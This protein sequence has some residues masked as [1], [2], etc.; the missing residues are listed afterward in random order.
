MG[1]ALLQSASEHGQL[2]LEAIRTSAAV[3]S[4]YLFGSWKIHVDVA[5]TRSVHYSGV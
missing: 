5:Q 3:Y 2:S 1:Y 4:C